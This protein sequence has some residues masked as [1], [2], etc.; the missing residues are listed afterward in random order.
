M[1]RPDTRLEND[2]D[3]EREREG[4]HRLPRHNAHRLCPVDAESVIKDARRL[5]VL[6]WARREGKAGAL[7][8]CFGKLAESC[9]GWRGGEDHRCVVLLVLCVP[10]VN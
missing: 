5:T 10:K 3:D 6:G 9:A 7:A 8:C 2:F 1:A 4:R